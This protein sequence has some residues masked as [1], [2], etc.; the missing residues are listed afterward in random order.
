MGRGAGNEE[1]DLEDGDD[2]W[3]RG[4]GWR[5]EGRGGGTQASPRGKFAETSQAIFTQ[6]NLV[7][8]GFPKGVFPKSAPHVHPSSHLSPPAVPQ[9]AGCSQGVPSSDAPPSP[10]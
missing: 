9:R 4:A 8:S 5:E 2:G 7:P 3:G 1:G 10:Q 6:G